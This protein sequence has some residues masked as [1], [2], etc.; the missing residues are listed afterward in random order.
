MIDNKVVGEAISK[1]RQAENMTQQALAA[2]L[3][4]SH[5][6]VSKWE[7]G[8]ALPD[9][10]T[11]LEISKLFGVTMEQLLSGDVGNRYEREMP[12]EKPIELKLDLDPL[13][14]RIE[15]AVEE[16][17]AA[18]REAESMA[19][20]DTVSDKDAPQPGAQAVESDTEKNTE[21]QATKSKAG[22]QAEPQSTPEGDIDIDIEKIISMAPFMSK[23]TV[24]EMVLRY[25]GKCTAKQL[26]KLAPFVS[27]ECLES[28]IVNNDNEINWD[29]LRR[30]APFLKREVVDALTLAVA[31]GEKYCRPVVKAVE[32]ST[33]DIG[34][35]MSHGFDKTLRKIRD[36]G[37]QIARQFDAGASTQGETPQKPADS[38]SRISIA[39]RRI[40][41]RALDE[42]KFDWIGE[43]IEQLDDEGVRARIIQRARELGMN[44]WINEY[45]EEA[46]DENALDE[47]IL[48][49]DWDYISDHLEDIDE[50]GFDLIVD[51]ALAEDKWDWLGANIDEMELS[52]E[53]KE[54]VVRAA[55]EKEKWDFLSWIVNEVE[56]SADV[57][58]ALARAAI[59]NRKWDF[60][61]A[62]ID[63]LELGAF[64][65]EI[66]LK[67][68][69]AG[70]AEIASEL[71][72][73]AED[74]SDSS[75]IQALL[76]K[77]LDQGDADFALEIA[78][79]MKQNAVGDV[80]VRLAKAG[81]LK[82]IEGLLESLD[83]EYLSQL[84]EIASES[85][86][87][88]MIDKINEL[89]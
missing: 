41:E 84:L 74:A 61:S 77:A 16:A 54:A 76:Q 37:N 39:R 52:D 64:A 25:K 82:K 69:E 40:F 20:S 63:K 29:T 34:H 31:K 80:C 53:S 19:A 85:D 56:L 12:H 59:E 7:N 67:A 21:D 47:A 46:L 44:E 55:I 26:S 11:L 4:V 65:A 79:H 24:D 68:Y 8:S 51:C 43:H 81:Q 15:R 42:E 83:G 86:D 10:L 14:Q 45:M 88:D 60:L 58:E 28:L 18:V 3:N 71:I 89:L 32:K 23:E 33:N 57:S 17:N 38:T 78:E 27:S 75:Q 22:E 36:I 66:A 73:Q 6:A 70:R 72:E 50:E 48:A 30:F 35:T 49:K 87:W 9:V 62:I 1:M 13:S 2:C 5:Q